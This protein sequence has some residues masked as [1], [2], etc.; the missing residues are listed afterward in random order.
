MTAPAATAAILAEDAAANFSRR[1]WHA[2]RCDRRGPI[3]HLRMRSCK[4]ILDGTN[5]GQD[6]IK[7]KA[8]GKDQQYPPAKTA[9]PQLDRLLSRWIR[10][11]HHLP[12]LPPKT[13]IIDVLAV[14][15]D[16]DTA[17]PHL[18]SDH[19]QRPLPGRRSKREIELADVRRRQLNIQR[20]TILSNV[21]GIAR[22]RNRDDIFRSQHPRQSHLHG[23]HTMTVCDST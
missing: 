18:S 3:A 10:R 20:R 11:S 12:G 17:N 13:S 9:P 15:V 23:G 7:A 21:V 8:P 1:P 14:A 5:R 22:P 6:R 2:H 4:C 19:L 16:G